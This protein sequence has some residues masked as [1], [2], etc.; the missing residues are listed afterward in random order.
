MHAPSF[1]TLLAERVLE[2][3]GMK[4]TDCTGQDQATGHWYGRP[5]EPFALPGMPAAGAVRSSARDMLAYLAAHLDPA[6][7]GCASG[8]RTTGHPDDRV[9]E[10][11]GGH[12]PALRQALAQVSRPLL[13]HP[14]SAD[15]LGLVWNIRQR[16][17]HR[18]VFHAGAT[19]GFTAFAGFSPEARVAVVALANAAGAGGCPALVQHAYLTLRELADRAA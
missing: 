6:R 17:G 15:Q 14:R 7:A 2:P 11:A 12:A 3:L 5:R 18:L 9:R 19:P 8:A 16:P 4:R 10:Q 1:A 13:R